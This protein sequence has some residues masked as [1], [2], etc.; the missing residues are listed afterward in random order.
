MALDNCFR[1]HVLTN[2]NIKKAFMGY[3]ANDEWGL[4]VKVDCSI[5]STN[6]DDTCVVYLQAKKELNDKGNAEFVAVV[7]GTANAKAKYGYHV[8]LFPVED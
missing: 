1:S 3:D 5:S 6:N 4:L 2:V 7:P 8:V